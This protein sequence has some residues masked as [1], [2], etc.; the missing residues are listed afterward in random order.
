MAAVERAL[1]SR[2]ELRSAADRTLVVA[3]GKAAVAMLR[4]VGPGARGFAI[5]PED[6]DTSGIPAGVEVLRGGH[7]LPTPEGLAASRQVLAAVSRLDERARLLYLVSGGS[8]A[9]F[10]V[11]RDG[12]DD[13]DVIDTYSLLLASGM[14]IDEMNTI[15]RAL[16]RTKG[17]GLARAAH[18]ARVHTLAVS[19]VPGDVAID[20]GS[21]PTVAASDAPGA[22]LAL[23]E[24]YD[25]VGALPAAVLA[26]LRDGARAPRDQAPALAIE[27]FEVVVRA[28]QAE[29]AAEDHLAEADYEIVSSPIAALA[30][31]AAAAAWGL[32]K[33][34]ES[35]AAGAKPVAFVLAGETTVRLPENPGRGG[36][37]QHFAA[38][39]A[40]ALAGLEGFACMVG[41][42]DG[43]DGNSDAAGAIIDGL[44]AARRDGG[45]SG[46]PR[47]DLA[48]RQ[49][50]RARRR[51]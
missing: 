40:G 15:R 18:P 13:D 4:G 5:V 49:R 21:G 20:I 38:V 25:L 27:A 41:G 29:E 24:R 6:A 33:S 12:I 48:F 7:P 2:P 19:D 28:T 9:L 3:T 47:R 45:R 44:T 16:S 37:N 22:A 32:I 51:G 46:S 34:F 10:E 1:R 23:A 14:P 31:D 42:T 17:G 26:V 36:R 30:G 43:R 35:L 8:S 50:Q 11:P 39:L